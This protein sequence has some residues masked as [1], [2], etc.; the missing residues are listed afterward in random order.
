MPCEEGILLL[1]VAGKSTLLQ[2]RSIL[3]HWISNW[4]N[5]HSAWE[6]SDLNGYVTLESDT[7][8]KATIRIV[9][10][11]LCYVRSPGVLCN[12]LQP[13]NF[14]QILKNFH[15]GIDRKN[16]LSRECCYRQKSGGTAGAP[17]QTSSLWMNMSNSAASKASWTITKTPKNG[18]FWG[19]KERRHTN[20]ESLQ[21]I[22]DDRGNFKSF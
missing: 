10:L 16:A 21:Q 5:F 2:T 14:N 6:I 19:R 9:S 17:P 8:R 7:T 20:D 3:Q 22:G 11:F 13:E 15:W 4:W 12:L 1:L 18:F